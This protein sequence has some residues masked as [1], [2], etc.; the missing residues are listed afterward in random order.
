MGTIAGTVGVV[1]RGNAHA[2]RLLPDLNSFDTVAL[3]GTVHDAAR[4][5]YVD[6]ASQI[7]RQAS[8]VVKA[9]NGWKN[10]LLM[11]CVPLPPPTTDD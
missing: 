10:V 9:R 5:S 7:E 4:Q 11:L 3:N 2:Y 6:S 8:F 1:A